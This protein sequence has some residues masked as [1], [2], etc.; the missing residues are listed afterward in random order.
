MELS[1]DFINGPTLE[2]NHGNIMKVLLSV[3]EIRGSLGNYMV[4]AELGI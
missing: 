2:W 3:M 4:M 1:W